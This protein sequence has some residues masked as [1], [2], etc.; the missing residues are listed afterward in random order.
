MT[1]IAQC[2]R[3]EAETGSMS[4]MVPEP[5][6]A[7]DRRTRCRRR[8][9]VAR[10]VRS[11][12]RP[13][14][15]ERRSESAATLL[16]MRQRVAHSIT[17]SARRHGLCSDLSLRSAH[18]LACAR[19][20]GRGRPGREIART[21]PCFETRRSEGVATLLSMRAKGFLMPE[22]AVNQPLLVPG[23]PDSAQPNRRASAPAFSDQ[24]GMFRLANALLAVTRFWRASFTLPMSPCNPPIPSLQWAARG[25]IPRSSAIDRAS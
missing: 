9:E 10:N 2:S 22:P 25:R 8:R 14:A 13:H 15:E 11:R 19:L 4:T 12:D 3:R 20:E 1:A 17:S 24:N 7:G 23:W 18:A 6:P 16:G 21:P 5:G